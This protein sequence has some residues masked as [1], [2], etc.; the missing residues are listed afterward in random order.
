MTHAPHPWRYETVGSHH[1]TGFFHLYLIDAN[2]RK[3]ACIWGKTEEKIDTAQHIL[4]GV[5]LLESKES[6]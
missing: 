4:D 3:I 6:A 1:G 2:G 5:R